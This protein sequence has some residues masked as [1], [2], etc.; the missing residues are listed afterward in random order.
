[1]AQSLQAHD[2]TAVDVAAYYSDREPCRSEVFAPAA[3]AAM[4]A[5]RSPASAEEQMA[6]TLYDLA[7]AEADR[8]F[9]PFCW[10]TKMALAHMG[11]DVF[12][13][14][15]RTTEKDKLPQ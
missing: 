13:I 1:M 11:L 10:R 4:V 15:S 9:S 14:A 5:F 12:F 7:G 3:E 8:L 6:I 2:R